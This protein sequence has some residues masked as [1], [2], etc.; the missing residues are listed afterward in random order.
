M[1]KLTWVDKQ[2]AFLTGWMG[3]Y[4]LNSGDE[5]FFEPTP[6]F[7]GFISQGTT[8][9][10]NRAMRILADHIESTT[11]PIIDEWKGSQDPVVGLD[12]DWTKDKV[13]PGV[14]RY[15]APGHSRVAVNIANKHSPF[16]MGAILAHELTHQFLHTKGIR[17][18][19]VE[20]N[21]RMTDLAT[22]YCGLGKL[23]INGYDPI[24]WTQLK[25]Q[26]SVEYTYR[27]GYLSPE[28]LAAI[29]HQVCIFRAISLEAAKSNLTDHAL[30]CVERVSRRINK[31]NLKKQIQGTKKASFRDRIR[32]LFGKVM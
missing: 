22:V 30:Q 6:G 2:M 14:I 12:Y 20:E 3:P 5:F 13:A 27:V 29:L 8:D 23:T 7:Y 10:L 32:R 17:Y 24:S 16:V 26:G 18:P 21:E 28:D 1:I 15:T 9:A 11:C 4:R 25:Q 19:D 31:Y